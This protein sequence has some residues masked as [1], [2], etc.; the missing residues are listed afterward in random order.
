MS[1]SAM[2]TQ[3]IVPRTGGDVRLKLGDALKRAQDLYEKGDLD[4]AER[5]AQAI[6]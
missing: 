3:P 5:F 6:V 4:G 2:T 1:G